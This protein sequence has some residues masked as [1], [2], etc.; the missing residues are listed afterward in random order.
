M[1]ELG[2]AKIIPAVRGWA[3]YGLLIVPP[4][5]N[6]LKPPRFVF[7]RPPLPALPATLLLFVVWAAD[8]S[9]ARMRAGD[10]SVAVEWALVSHELSRIGQLLL[11]SLKALPG[12]GTAWPRPHSVGQGEQQR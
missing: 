11:Q 7:S 10:V 3:A 2:S 12:L 5:S 1:W 4:C 6:S 8:I 9:V